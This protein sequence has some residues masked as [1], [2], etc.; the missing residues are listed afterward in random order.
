M[1]HSDAP[2]RFDPVPHRAGH[3]I[4]GHIVPHGAQV[5]DPCVAYVEGVGSADLA[6]MLAA[7]EM[8]AALEAFATANQHADECGCDDDC[9]IAIRLWAGAHQTGLAALAKSKGKV[10][11]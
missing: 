8:L 3:G 4:E 1:R 2:W 5:D 9:D 11:S 10:V 7:P 6:L